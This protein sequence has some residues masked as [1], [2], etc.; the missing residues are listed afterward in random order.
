MI[1]FEQIYEA[2]QNQLSG[3]QKKISVQSPLGVYFGYSPDGMLRLSFMSTCI[4]PKLDST[5]NLRVTQGKEN[6]GVYWT[7]YDLLQSESK[8]VFFTFCDDLI[9]SV[10]GDINEARVLAFLRK[11]YITWKTMFKKE[12]ETVAPRE[13]LQG[14]FGELYF[15]KE[16]LI[17]K[18][19][20][21]TA[22]NA[23]SGPAAASKDYA[24]EK[25]WYEVKTIGANTNAVEISSLTQLA[26]EY[27]GHLAIIRV[28]A[29]AS[30]FC[31]GKSCIGELLKHIISSISDE[32]VE[33]IFLNKVSS[34]GFDLS[35]ENINAKFDVKSLSLYRV[36]ERFP[37]ITI[38]DIGFPEICSV[39][40][41]LSVPALQRYL[42][43]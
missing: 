35:D 10:I 28:E 32:T 8:K 17:D 25:D 3:N 2:L 5:K 4:P 9:G 18:F 20:V 19:G 39:C 41:A 29:M 24:V 40:Y 21:N 34:Y 30:T 31:N 15:L 23:W 1:D 6:D 13:M 33:S 16:Y 38:N 26:S 37:R 14:L 27:P 11:R 7:S 42:E 22:V 43:E 12:T 36:D